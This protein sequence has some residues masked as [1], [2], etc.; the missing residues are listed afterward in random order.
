MWRACASPTHISCPFHVIRP[1]GFLY[2]VFLNYKILLHVENY[3]VGTVK[4]ERK[5]TFTMWVQAR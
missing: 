1:F 3:V 5:K 4:C 2:L